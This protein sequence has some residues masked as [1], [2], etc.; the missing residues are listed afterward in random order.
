[1][2]FIVRSREAITKSR[3]ANFCR[4]KVKLALMIPEKAGPFA[5]KDS[6]VGLE[7]AKRPANEEF[8]L[9][10]NPSNVIKHD[11]DALW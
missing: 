8:S 3:R 11:L 1:M 6:N 7:H 9:V 10:A 5:P 2:D 4:A